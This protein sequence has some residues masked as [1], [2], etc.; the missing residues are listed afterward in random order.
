MP[1]AECESHLNQLSGDAAVIAEVL[2]LVRAGE[3]VDTAALIAPARAMLNI[4]PAAPIAQPAPGEVIGAWQIDRE[5]GHGGMGSVFLVERNDGHFKQTAALKFLRGSPRADTLD[6]F[7]RERQLLAG[8]THPNIARLLDAGTVPDGRPFFG[9]TYFPP[10]HWTQIL[11]ELETR[12]RAAA[13][14]GEDL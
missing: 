12:A 14:N 9:G 1:N 7:T 8:L 10:N 3:A 13:D 6:Y 4:V 2:A 11:E 5:I